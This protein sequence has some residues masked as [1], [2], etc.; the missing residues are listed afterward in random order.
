MNNRC[1]CCNKVLT[2]DELAFQYDWGEPID[3]CLECLGETTM[4]DHEELEEVE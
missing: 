4:F 2:D 3:L 1:L